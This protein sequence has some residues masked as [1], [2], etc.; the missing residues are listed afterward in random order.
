MKFPNLSWAGSQSRL[1]NYQ[2]AAIASMSESRFSRC[3]TGRTEFSSDER[4]RLARYFGYPEEW[5]FQ[6]V[7][8]PARL[9]A[10]MRDAAEVI[11]V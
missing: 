11:A 4:E 6:Q 5:L 2:V 9:D 8:P 1:A 3:L 10:V 7:N